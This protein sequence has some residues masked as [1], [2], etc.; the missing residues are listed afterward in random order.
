MLCGWK[1][2]A[3]RAIHLIRPD[4]GFL[5]VRRYFSGFID[6]FVAVALLAWLA[7][8]AVAADRVVLEPVEDP[9]LAQFL[10]TSG[11]SVSGSSRARC[12]FI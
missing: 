6:A 5:K 8:A 9:E 10:E 7:Q 12:L 11:S 1:N 2:P 3:L 4:I